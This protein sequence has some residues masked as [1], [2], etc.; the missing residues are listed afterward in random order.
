MGRDTYNKLYETYARIANIVVV[1]KQYMMKIME[2]IKSIF[3]TLA[4]LFYSLGSM[5]NGPIGGILRF[6]CFSGETKILT[7]NNI[8]VDIKNIKLGDLLNESQVVNCLIEIYKADKKMYPITGGL[9]A[10]SHLIQK[11][12]YNKDKIVYERVENYFK[13]NIL[14]KDEIYCLGTSNNKISTLENKFTDYFETD[15]FEVQFLIF[16]IVKDFVNNKFNVNEKVNLHK[17]LKKYK[18]NDCEKRILK[19][20]KEL[21]TNLLGGFIDTTFVNTLSVTPQSIDYI[22]NNKE[23][24]IYKTK[25]VGRVKAIV[26]S[27]LILYKYR[28]LNGTPFNLIKVNNEWKAL[29]EI[30]TSFSLI[31]NNYLYNIITTTNQ[32]N[33]GIYEVKDFEYHRSEELN[34][35]LDQIVKQN[36]NK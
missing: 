10:G 21:K 25:V 14:H 18:L 32:F 35:V 5:W 20:Y 22:Y 26:P 23:V 12:D 4:F 11:Y 27:S 29:Y 17:L 19:N 36:L 34:N 33:S 8:P 7:Q 15:N 1:I 2:L 31:N 13:Q 28:H 9:V 24:N 3:V 16:K 6:F 30:G